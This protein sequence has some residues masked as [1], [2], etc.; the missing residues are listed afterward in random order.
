M[1]GD[2][3]SLA[4]RGWSDGFEW[5]VFIFDFNSLLFGRCAVLAF[6]TDRVF[7]LCPESRVVLVACQV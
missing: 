6:N 4:F 5:F 7:S 2:G 3:E 1:V